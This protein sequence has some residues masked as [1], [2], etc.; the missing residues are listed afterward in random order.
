[1]RAVQGKKSDLIPIEKESSAL[2]ID[3]DEIAKLPQYET[4][5]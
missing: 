2:F 4:I 3:D 5:V 1:M